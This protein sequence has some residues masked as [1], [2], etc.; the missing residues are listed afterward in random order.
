MASMDSKEPM[1]YAMSLCG[2]G[3][4]SQDIDPG[5]SLAES[6][7][8]GSSS[9]NSSRKKKIKEKFKEK[10]D[11]QDFKN[12]EQE[13]ESM[14]LEGRGKRSRQKMSEILMLANAEFEEAEAEIKRLRRLVGQQDMKIESIKATTQNWIEVNDKLYNDLRDVQENNQEMRDK[15]NVEFNAK[16]AAQAEEIQDLNEEIQD[17]NETLEMAQE[18]VQSLTTKVAELRVSNTELR[19]EVEAYKP[20]GNECIACMEKDRDTVMTQCGHFVL[21]FGCAEALP[22]NYFGKVK[23]PLC[24]QEKVATRADN[25]AYV[26]II[27]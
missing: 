11:Q 7:L 8:A 14:Q 26:K 22:R 20:E 24:R 17:L 19:N 21:C 23:C 12:E 15:M 25:P 10:K 16:I 5:S 4:A 1:T 27:R 3:S 13:E 9:G 18:E 2:N 6:S